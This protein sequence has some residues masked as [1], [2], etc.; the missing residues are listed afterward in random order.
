MNVVSLSCKGCN[1]LLP[2]ATG[3]TIQC[4]LHYATF[5]VTQPASEGASPALATRRRCQRSPAFLV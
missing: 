3:P 4:E 1:A 5:V 2:A